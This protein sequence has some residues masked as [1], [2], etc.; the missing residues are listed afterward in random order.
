MKQP[1]Y[2]SSWGQPFVATDCPHC[3]WI[4]LTLPQKA[5]QMCPHC[6][7]AALVPLD[8]EDELPYTHPP[9][10]MIR[11]PL[12]KQQLESRLASFAEDVPYAPADLTSRNLLSRMRR[13]YLPMWLVDVDVSGQWQAEVGYDYKVVS[14]RERLQN[15]TWRSEEVEETRIR[16]E[17]RLGELKRHYANASAAALDEQHI[18]SEKIGQY[19]RVEAVDFHP[20]DMADAFVRLPNRPPQDAWSDAVPVVQASAAAECRCASGGQ[21]IRQFKWSPSFDGQRWTQLLLESPAPCLPS[22]EM[23]IERRLPLARRT[24]PHQHIK[25]DSS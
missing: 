19:D 2:T 4:F 11:P 10:M 18:L 6:G 16:W 21:H 13:V 14:H 24:R 20:A 15:Q 22:L 7:Q 1:G 25:N 5:E 23:Q 9:E 3:D 8:G 17:P 12:T